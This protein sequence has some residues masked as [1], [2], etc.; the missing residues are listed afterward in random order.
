MVVLHGFHSTLQRLVGCN[1][2]PFS[3]LMNVKTRNFHRLGDL[4]ST[5]QVEG[6]KEHLFLFFMAVGAEASAVVSS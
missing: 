1:F 4:P 3:L 2:F 6:K 5:L